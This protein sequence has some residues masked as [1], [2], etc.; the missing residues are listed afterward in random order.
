M[1]DKLL[2]F[3]VNSV[4]AEEKA[5]YDKLEESRNLAKNIARPVNQYWAEVDAQELIGPCKKKAT[6]HREREKFWTTKLEEAEKELREKGVSVEVFDQ[7]TQTYMNPMNSLLSGAITG[8]AFQSFQP[9]VDQ[10]LLDN[11]KNCK[12]KMLEHREKVVGYEKLIRAFSF[13]PGYRVKLSIDDVTYYGLG[14]V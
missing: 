8:A 14:E 13:N 6:T 9:R 3:V 10:K 1:F 5:K 2:E 12:N 7:N 11:V 4:R